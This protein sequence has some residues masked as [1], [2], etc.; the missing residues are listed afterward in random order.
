[1]NTPESGC[2]QNIQASAFIGVFREKRKEALEKSNASFTGRSGE[3]RTRGLLNPK[4]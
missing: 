1:L 4:G 3:I 2:I